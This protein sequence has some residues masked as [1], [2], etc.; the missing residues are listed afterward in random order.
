MGIYLELLGDDL[1]EGGPKGDIYIYKCILWMDK[2]LHQFVTIGNYD[3][4]HSTGDSTGVIQ[5]PTGDSDFFHSQ[6]N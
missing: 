5:L 4:P 1:Q 2:I 6:A 3:T